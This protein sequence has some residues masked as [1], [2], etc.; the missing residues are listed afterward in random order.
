MDEQATLDELKQ[1]GAATPA[2]ASLRGLYD[3]AFRDYGLTDLFHTEPSSGPQNSGIV[4]HTWYYG[5]SIAINTSYSTK[6]SLSLNIAAIVSTQR[7][8]IPY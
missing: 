1:R 5:D 3:A 8:Q 7:P 6:R 4:V 2:P